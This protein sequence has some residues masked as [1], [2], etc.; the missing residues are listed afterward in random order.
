MGTLK[1]R[2]WLE[3]RSS[4]LGDFATLSR[5]LSNMTEMDRAEN[6]D[7]I[8]EIAKKMSSILEMVDDQKPYTATDFAIACSGTIQKALSNGGVANSFGVEGGDVGAFSFTV[9]DGEGKERRLRVE[10][11]EEVV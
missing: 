3:E 4:L 5:C 10:V 7:L 8:A 9:K 2:E 11:M 6:G 1:M